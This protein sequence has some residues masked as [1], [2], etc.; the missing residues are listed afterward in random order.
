LFSSLF[1]IIITTEVTTEMGTHFLSGMINQTGVI[2]PGI[3][4][5][6]YLSADHD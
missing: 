2:T 3:F 1:N 4:S 5:A 6:F